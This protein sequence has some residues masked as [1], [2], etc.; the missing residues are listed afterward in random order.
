MPEFIIQRISP[1]L[2]LWRHIE[3]DEATY[4]EDQNWFKVRRP[5]GLVISGKPDL[6]TINKEGKCK[7]YDAKTGNPRLGDIIQVMLYMMCL[8][9]SSPVYKGKEIEG[10]VVYKNGNKSE[11]P[12]SA[13]DEEFTKKVTYFLDILQSE[14]APARTP[15]P[16]ECKFCDIG[17]SDCDSRKEPPDV[18]STEGGEPGIQI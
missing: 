11:I 15:A 2:F 9:L 12:A 6:I 14:N 7:V 13:I 5:S 4:L 17:D 8:P 10:C 3:L 18:E 1:Q 16:M